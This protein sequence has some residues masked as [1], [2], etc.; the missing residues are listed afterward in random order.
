[1]L[2]I[3]LALF[4][5]HSPHHPLIHGLHILPLPASAYPL[6]SPS[7]SLSIKC[8]P[9]LSG[10]LCLV[11]HTLSSCVT[12]FQWPPLSKPH[13]S[14]FLNPPLSQK[15]TT[16]TYS[17]TACKYYHPS[18]NPLSCTP[19]NTAIF[20]SLQTPT[21]TLILI[22]PPPSSPLSHSTKSAVTQSNFLSF[23]SS[24][25]PPSTYH[26]QPIYPL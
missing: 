22:T 18:Q 19:F 4:Q 24:L 12:I 15:I 5:R 14:F 8:S 26:H 1:M 16:Y 13:I 10:P 9:L 23:A 20:C 6:H 3:T 17:D 21:N 25:P 2:K 11:H 7:F